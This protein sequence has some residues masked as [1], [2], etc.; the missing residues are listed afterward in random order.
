MVNFIIKP[1]REDFGYTREHSLILQSPSRVVYNP[2]SVRILYKLLC[3]RV[4]CVA[5][6]NK[7]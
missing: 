4:H 2:K 1:S 5:F 6:T 3:Y 7:Y